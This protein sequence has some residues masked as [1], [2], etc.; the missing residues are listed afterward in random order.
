V[1]FPRI[2]AQVAQ[3]KKAEV[4]EAILHNARALFGKRGYLKCR[5]EEIAGAC[6][7]SVSNLYVYFPSKVH[8]FYEVY[9]PMLVSRIM[10]LAKDARAIGDHHARLRFILLTLWRD[11]PAENNGFANY[12]IQ[13]IVTS[14]ADVEKPHEPLKYCEAF[15]TEL[16]AECLSEDKKALVADGLFAFLAW[17]AFDG[18][19]ANIGKHEQRD[20]E[21]IADR[22]ATMLIGA[23]P[24]TRR[25]R[26]PKKIARRRSN[27]SA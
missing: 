19:A 24:E 1:L 26:Q 3:T 25:A 22:V 21:I 17:M 12:L 11:L 4:R 14:P 15:V 8:L 16:I 9:T 18:F 23:Q 10:Q 2:K 6:G 13:A 20:V 5:M 7:M 27:A